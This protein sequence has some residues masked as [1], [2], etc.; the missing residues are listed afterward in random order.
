M[1]PL[2]TIPFVARLI[3]GC[4]FGQAAPASAPISLMALRPGLPT[5][6]ALT[7]DMAM[8]VIAA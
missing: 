2:A 5:V 6:L 1:R 3:S 4:A 7:S 8:V